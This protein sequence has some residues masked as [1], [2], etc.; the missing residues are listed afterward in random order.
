MCDVPANVLSSAELA[1]SQAEAA[2]AAAVRA[3]VIRGAGCTAYVVHEGVGAG[4]CSSVGRRC[5]GPTVRG[6][7]LDGAGA[8]RQFKFK[9][10]VDIQQIWKKMQINCILV[11][12]S[13][14]SLSPH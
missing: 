13:F 3:V 5:L 6:S 2:P 4:C 8:G 11:T 7:Q 10:S 14:A 9:F 12:S 1:M